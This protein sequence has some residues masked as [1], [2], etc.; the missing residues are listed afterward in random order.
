MKL[1]YPRWNT[2]DIVPWQM[3]AQKAGA[4]IKVIPLLDNGELDLDVYETLL[5][6]RTRMVF[7]NSQSCFGNNSDG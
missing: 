2:P 5:N 4:I 7:R 3:I 6:E 1:F